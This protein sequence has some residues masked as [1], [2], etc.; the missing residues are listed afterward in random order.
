MTR[1][2][3]TFPG[4]L[5]PLLLVALLLA[6]PS[7]A[8]ATEPSTGTIE[9]TVTLEGGGVA[10]RVEVCTFPVPQ[11]GGEEEEWKCDSTGADGKYEITGIRPG[12]HDVQ[13]WPEFPTAYLYQYY[14]DAASYEGAKPVL[15]TAGGVNS[16]V[17]AVLEEGATVSGTVTA[18]ATGLPVAGV[19]VWVES[20]EG[21][22]GRGVTD[23]AG[24]YTAEGLPAGQYYAYFYPEESGLELVGQSYPDR[25]YSEEHG[26][27]TVGA[28]AHVTGIDAALSVGGQ[29][30]GTVR[31]ASSGSPLGGVEICLTE[32][33]RVGSR[34][35]L[36]TGASGAYEFR[37]VWAGSWKVA[38]S[39]SLADIYGEEIAGYIEEEETPR[40]PWRD[41]FPTQWWSGQ[42][43]FATATPIA[44]TPAATVVGIDAS[45]GT[46]AALVQP[47]PIPAATIVAPVVAKA[48]PKPKKPLR[49]KHGLLKRKVHGKARCVRRHVAI[50]HPRKKKHSKHHA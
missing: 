39:P 46:P 15:V 11:L 25:T 6:M 45:L 4:L 1:R 35:C 5:I 7:A 3:W 10:A 50:E 28:K 32:A 34:G 14:D 29:I 33:A 31:S 16:N 21:F 38:F 37:G 13:F 30:H 36:V 27:F 12:E 2:D 44:L 47:A 18:A 43:T 20:E 9:G 40:A 22:E 19:E 42:T 23:A 24:R 48:K 8:G 26:I 17:D 49:C 41:A